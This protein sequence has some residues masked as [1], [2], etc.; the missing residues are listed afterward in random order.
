MIHRFLLIMIV[1]ICLL[2]V[3]PAYGDKFMRGADLSLL[4]FEE[5]HGVEF[6]QNGQPKD[7]VL[8]FKTHGCNYVR[9]RLFVDPDGTAGQVNTLPYTLKLAKRVRSAGL[10]FLLDLHY[11]DQWADPGHQQIPASWKT[12][13]HQQLVQ[14]VTDYTRDTLNAFKAEDAMPGMVEIGNEITNGMMWPDGGPIG[15]SAPNSGNDPWTNLTDLLKAGIHGLRESDPDQHVKAMIHIDNGGNKNI[16]RWFFDNI[17]GRGV[18]FD[19][20]GLSYYPFWNGSL[21]D[22]KANLASLSRAYKKD[23]VVVE[24]AYNADGGPQGKLP[25][26]PTPDGQG[27]YLREL[28]ETIAST[29]DEH[30]AGICVW[31]PDWIQGRKWH[32][33]DWSGQWESRAFFDKTGNMRPAM[34]AFATALPVNLVSGGKLPTRWDRY[35][36]PNDPLGDY[37]RPQMVR[38]Q[39]QSLNGMWDYALTDSTS[40][41]APGSFDGRI[42]VPFPYESALSGVGNPSIPKQCLWYRRT[43]EAPPGWKAGSR[44]LLHFGAVNWDASVILNGRPLGEHKGGYDAFGFD[45]TGA[46][47]PR[48]NQLVVAVRNPLRSDVPDSQISGKQRLHPGGVLYTG[49]TGIWQSVWIE[50]VPTVHI[51][52][53]KINSDIDNKTLGVTAIVAGRAANVTVTVSD[54]GNIIGTTTGKAGAPLT[55]PISDPHLWS[56]DDP[57]LYYLHITTGGEDAVDSYAAMRK[58]SL[59][60]DG[61]NR[62]CILLNNKAIF[63]IGALD[64]GY[65]PDGIYTAPTDDALKYDIEIAKQLDLICC[66]STRK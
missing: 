16:S 8:M 26:P 28:I 40:D 48:K 13:T 7:P 42:L 22:L 5:D 14:K 30:G 17:L 49:C 12:L 41:T 34:E 55:I 19:V 27:D 45:I 56:P 3:I 39:W 11:S 47:K 57:H 58:I 46:I 23:I 63:Q 52:D 35:I 51:E 24:T 37:P 36:S 10:N 31:E 1:I 18:K 15:K 20:I 32:A 60:R 25:F 50:P 66:A 62:V 64:Q 21:H 2:G 65:W 44:I 38:P 33:A 59:G 29:A 4:Q 54:G 53:L 61:D 6:K 9:L 43:F